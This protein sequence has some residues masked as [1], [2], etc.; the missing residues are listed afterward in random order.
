M[1]MNREQAGVFVMGLLAL[2]VALPFTP[3]IMVVGFFMGILL[4]VWM[5][6]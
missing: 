5:M 6:P 2:T 4:A 3:A 1:K